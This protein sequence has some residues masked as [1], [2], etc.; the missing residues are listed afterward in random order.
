MSD[1]FHPA[2]QWRLRALGGMFGVFTLAAGV[3][4][5]ALGGRLPRTSGACP[6]AARPSSSWP[7]LWP[8]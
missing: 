7:A 6:R 4:A 8:A 2:Q 3:G 5:V 1:R